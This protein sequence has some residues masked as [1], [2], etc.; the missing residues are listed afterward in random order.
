MNSFSLQTTKSDNF[1]PTP[2]A[3][4]PTPGPYSYPPSSSSQPSASPATA[5]A[6]ATDEGAWPALEKTNY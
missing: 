1:Q 4:Y 3:T 2:V 5:P 6:I